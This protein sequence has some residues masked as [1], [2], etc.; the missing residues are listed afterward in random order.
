MANSPS[1]T[2]PA[3]P[4]VS[5][6]TDAF[7]K[8]V[9]IDLWSRFSSRLW[10]TVGIFLTFITIAGYTGIRH[11]IAQEI[12]TKLAKAAKSYSVKLE[13]IAAR[14]KLLALLRSEYDL[15]L[16]AITSGT[17]FV[18]A[19][20]NLPKAGNES[21][22]KSDSNSEK[23]PAHVLNILISDP[24]I[25]SVVRPVIASNNEGET[26]EEY[27]ISSF[28]A[29]FNIKEEDKKKQLTL[30]K[31]LTW[32]EASLLMNGARSGD[33]HPVLDGTLGGFITDLKYRL[34]ALAA[35]KKTIDYLNKDILKIGEMSSLIDHTYKRGKMFDENYYHNAFNQTLFCS[36]FLTN[37]EQNNFNTLMPL[38][39]PQEKQLA[40]LTKTTNS[41]TSCEPSTGSEVQSTASS[42]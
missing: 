31:R 29:L 42:R 27:K 34:V 32:H 38:Y 30:P 28:S 7:L 24:E 8:Y 3:Q 21:V 40:F 39:N 13:D 33:A 22:I 2:E 1:S 20:L 4:Q 10:T 25:Y 18:I 15:R 35:I 17:E 19:T 5:L 14:T 23:D 6:T 9:E 26:R 36:L 11:F 41:E 16:C 37:A 12:E